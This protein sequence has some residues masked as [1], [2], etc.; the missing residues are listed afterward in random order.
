MRCGWK[1]ESLKGKVG[2][3]WK[4]FTHNDNVGTALLCWTQRP[5]FREPI[6]VGIVCDPIDDGCLFF[7]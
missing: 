5:A 3:G 4:K 1:L 6:S 7:C 2:E